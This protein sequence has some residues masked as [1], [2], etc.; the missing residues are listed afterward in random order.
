MALGIGEGLPFSAHAAWALLEG[1]PEHPRCSRSAQ[2]WM[3][4]SAMARED[5]DTCRM[6]VNDWSRPPG[7]PSVTVSKFIPGQHY[8]CLDVKFDTLDEA[9]RHLRQM[10][11]EYGGVY[12]HRIFRDGD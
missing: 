3:L 6:Y 10:G 2:Y 5:T 9:I 1:L 7:R 12:E 11:Y 4:R 8:H